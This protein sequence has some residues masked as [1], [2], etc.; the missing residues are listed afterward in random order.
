MSPDVEP[1]AAALTTARGIRN[2]AASERERRGRVIELSCGAIE[3]SQLASLKLAGLANPAPLDLASQPNPVFWGRRMAIGQGSGPSRAWC[4]AGRDK[5][6]FGGLGQVAVFHLAQPPKLLC[7]RWELP[8][9]TGA[10]LADRLTSA[11]KNGGLQPRCGSSTVTTGDGG[12]GACLS[13]ILGRLGKQA[14]QCDRLT[15]SAQ[16]AQSLKNALS[17]AVGGP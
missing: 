10:V 1:H 16:L 5:I 7:S 17:W 2:A 11:P 3:P 4:C 15:Q 14:A 8:P 9:F 6:L 13:A 12:R